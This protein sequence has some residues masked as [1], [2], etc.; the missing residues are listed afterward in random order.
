MAKNGSAVTQFKP[1]QV[2]NPRGRPK[3]SRDRLQRSFI[4]ALTADFEEHGPGAIRICRMEQ[5]AQYLNV[6]A[7]VIPQELLVESDLSSFTDAELAALRRV[8]AEE[9]LAPVIEIEV[10]DVGGETGS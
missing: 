9:A 10:E 7:K 8:L 2:P 4:D 3:G 5:P 6:I 1:G